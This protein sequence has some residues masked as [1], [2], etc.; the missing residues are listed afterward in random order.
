VPRFVSWLRE[1]F[2]IL[3]SPMAPTHESK[4]RAESLERE[5]HELKHQVSELRHAVDLL[6]LAVQA[7]APPASRV[8]ALTITFGPPSPR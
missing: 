4:K 5:L 2:A 1:W 7:L 6:T 8:A 3:V